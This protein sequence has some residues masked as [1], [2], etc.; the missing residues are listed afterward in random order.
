MSKRSSKG[1]SVTFSNE[2]PTYHLIESYK[3]KSKH[4][5]RSRS[6]RVRQVRGRSR[7]S[8]KDKIKVI[9]L[10]K[11][12]TTTDCPSTIESPIDPNCSSTTQKSTSSHSSS[13]PLKVGQDV[14]AADAIAELLDL[15]LPKLL[16]IVNDYYNNKN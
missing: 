11:K 5:V 14:N 8:K 1:L 4:F 3:S 16:Q 15:G 9:L 13:L 6:K 10:P 7:R 2:R 12:D